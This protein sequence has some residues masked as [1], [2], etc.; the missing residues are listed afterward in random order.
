MF[1]VTDRSQVGE[2]RRKAL[3]WAEDHGCGEDL[4]STVAL[5]VSE[6]AGNLSLHTRD[7]GSLVLRM[8]EDR[9]SDA[10][11][12]HS[13]DRGPGSANFGACMQDGY[14]TAGTAGTGLGAVSRAS[15]SFEVHS[16]PGVGTALRCVVASKLPQAPAAG[17]WQFGLL[18]VPVKGEQV[19]GDACSYQ[20]LE[21]GRVRML[22][23]DGLG[24]GPLAADAS[25]QA[26]RTFELKSHLD[27]P[28]LMENIHDALRATRGAAVAVAEIDPERGRVKYAGVGN[29]AGYI[30]RDSSETSHLVTMNGTLGVV[31][32]KI[33]QF[34][35]AWDAGAVLVMTSD[36]IKNHWRLDKYAGVMARHSSLLAGILFRDFAR[37]TDDMTVAVL[38][39]C[40]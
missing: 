9:G 37:Q 25:E 3:Q 17:R 34:E 28:T 4:R 21:D 23:A 40:S 12:I 2:A 36:G 32:P 19:C 31:R 33:Q 30:V 11:E 20:H 27:L 39:V 29:I 24:H 14:S 22:V 35:Y 38:R 1:E 7:G 18:N 16:Q 8:M 15:E 26:V 13:L 5:V 10:V 6:L